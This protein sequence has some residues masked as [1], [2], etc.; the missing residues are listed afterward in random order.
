MFDEVLAVAAVDPDLA[1]WGMF[2]GDAVDE[3]GVGGGVLHAG[4]GDH[5]REEEAERV[6]DDAPFAANAPWLR[7]SRPS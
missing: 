5:H 4:R 6:A 3:P 2:S 7:R 1:D